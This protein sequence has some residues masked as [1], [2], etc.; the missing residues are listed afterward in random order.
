MSAATAV[1]AMAAVAGAVTQMQAAKEAKKAGEAN[2]RL[3]EQQATEEKRRLALE[4]KA[5]QSS[6]IARTGAAGAKLNSGSTL[7]VLNEHLTEGQKEQDWLSQKGALSAASARLEG[8][9]A[10]SSL[11]GGAFGSMGN[12]ASAFR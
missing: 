7:A 3:Q 9:R 8:S 10:S 4:Q 6:L 1:M 12:A 5:T 11:M 2:A